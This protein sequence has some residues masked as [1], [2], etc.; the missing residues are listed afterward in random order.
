[1]QHTYVHTKIET[2]LN[3]IITAQARRTGRDRCDIINTTLKEGLMAKKKATKKA[4][5]KKK[6]Y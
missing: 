1:M 5:A 3:K 6:G 2:R 4:P